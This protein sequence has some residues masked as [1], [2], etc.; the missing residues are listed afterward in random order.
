MAVASLA[1]SGIQSLQ[2]PAGSPPESWQSVR[3]LSAKKMCGVCGAEFRPLRWNNS[4]GTQVT[5]ESRWN[6]QTTCSK[7]CSK[8]LLNPMRD[9]EARQKVR[10]K[11]LASGH[12][13][14][15]RGGNGVLTVPQESLLAILGDGWEAEHSVATGRRGAG[16]P[17]NYKIDIANRIRMI[18]IEVDG[19][20]HGLAARKAGDAKKTAFLASRGWSVYRVSNTRALSLCSTCT[21]ADTLLTSLMES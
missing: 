19:K 2:S 9:M 14:I 17:T 3:S 11:H 4:R 1:Q 12:R 10:A 20:S 7:S 6:A 21:S 8:K 18:A 16:Y 13:P 15:Q 5:A